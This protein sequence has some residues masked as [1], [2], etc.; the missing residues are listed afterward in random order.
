MKD[1]HDMCILVVDW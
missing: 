1:K